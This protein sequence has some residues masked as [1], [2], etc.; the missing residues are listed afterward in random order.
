[1][2]DPKPNLLSAKH[3]KRGRGPG[4]A[5]L[6]LALAYFCCPNGV[7]VLKIH[8]FQRNKNRVGQILAAFQEAEVISTSF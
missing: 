6:P 5:F 7:F 8:F 1:M 2:P 3:W 4:A